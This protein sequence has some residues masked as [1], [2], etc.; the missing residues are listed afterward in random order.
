MKG[1]DMP[2][3]AA[4][5]RLSD[6]RT[7]FNRVDDFLKAIREICPIPSVLTNSPSQPS[8]A[9]SALSSLRAALP[10]IGPLIEK[11][12]TA[13]NQRAYSHHRLKIATLGSRLRGKRGS[14]LV[15]RAVCDV[16]RS[17]TNDQVD[18]AM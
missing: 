3:E 4:R 6:F 15:E 14:S 11:T 5:R 9:R 16:K 13:K 8:A 2:T 1:S 18:V 10:L 7:V 17:R 12:C